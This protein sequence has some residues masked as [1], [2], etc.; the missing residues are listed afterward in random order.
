V[1]GL[2]AVNSSTFKVYPFTIPST[3]TPYTVDGSFAVSGDNESRIKVY[4]M[5]TTNLVNWQNGYDFSTYYNSGE[6]T[7]GNFQITSP[8]AG[9]TY[10]LVF[11]N[12]FSTTLKNI[13]THADAMYWPSD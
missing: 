2:I 1:N 9:G 10:F 6:A 3:A 12:T 4:I 8:P 13:D 5:N 7:Q 11:D